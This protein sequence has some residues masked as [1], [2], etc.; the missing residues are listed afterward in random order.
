[1][2]TVKDLIT[3]LQTMP[4]DAILVIPNLGEGGYSPLGAGHVIDMRHDLVVSDEAIN[5]TMIFIALDYGE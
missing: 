1:M 3:K 2:F 5:D 4:G